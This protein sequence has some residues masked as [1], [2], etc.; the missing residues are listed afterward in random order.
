M[1]LSLAGLGFPGFDAIQDVSCNASGL[2]DWTG[3]GSTVVSTVQVTFDS[4]ASLP[5]PAT[6]WLFAV[7]FIG[8]LG[9]G[10][11][12]LRKMPCSI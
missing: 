3:I 11:K 10:Q 1:C 7:G 4:V 8:L 9:M 5:L 6:I 2:C 12:H